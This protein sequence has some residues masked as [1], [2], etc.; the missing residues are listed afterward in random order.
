MGIDSEAKRWRMLRF[1]SPV[2]SPIV[3]N[4][5]DNGADSQVERAT[6]LYLYGGITFDGETYATTITVEGITGGASLSTLSYVVFDAADIGT[7]SIIKQANDEETNA[8]GDLTI[9]LTGLS[10]SLDTVLTIVI[11]NYTTTPSDS[12]RGA[13]C[14]GTAA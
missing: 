6:V 4:P 11:T 12:D 13:V 3:F 7:A 9:D 5:T 2:V 10:V 8:S 1:A 14:Y